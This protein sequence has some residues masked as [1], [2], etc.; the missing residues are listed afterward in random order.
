VRSCLA[1]SR[2]TQAVKAL[3]HI[4]GGGFVEN[5]P[6]VLPRETAVSIDLARVP[7][8]PVFKWLAATGGVSEQEMLR[9]FNC[10]IG[11]V[12]I[13]DPSFA[14]AAIEQFTGHGET[15]VRLGE[16][17]AGGGA[18]VVNFRGRLDLSS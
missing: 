4:T 6:R 5:I 8:L 16:V 11:M 9:T 10:G 7:V 14:G 3:A 18:P 12:A 15:V 1:A 2:K 13:L 17:V